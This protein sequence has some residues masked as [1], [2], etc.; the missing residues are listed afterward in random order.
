[1]LLFAASLASWSA[2]SFPRCPAWAFIYVNSTLYSCSSISFIFV[3]ISSISL[4]C[5]FLFCSNWRFIWLSV[6]IRTI[7]TPVSILC[8]CSNAFSIAICSDWLFVHLSLNLYFKVD[9]KLLSWYI[10]IP[11]PTPASLLLPSVYAWILCG[12][13]VFVSII[14]TWNAGCQFEVCSNTFWAWC[15][16]LQK[17]SSS[18]K[19]PRTRH[20]F[21]TFAMFW[22]LCVFFWVN[23]WPLNFICRRF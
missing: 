14:L 23:P 15:S 4:V 2:V 12:L 19:L 3:L 11:A 5:F 6:C 18:V 20:F 21:H 13:S 1:M 22:M 16:K 8:M 7:L 9:V 17:D 10:A